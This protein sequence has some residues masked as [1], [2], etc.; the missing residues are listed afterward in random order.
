MLIRPLLGVMS[1]GGTR[2]RLSILIFHRV[3]PQVDPLFPQEMQAQRFDRLC[4]W[5]AQWFDVLPLDEAVRRLKG[6][7]LPQ[8]A[9]AITFDDGYADNHDVAMPILKKHGLCATFFIATGFLDGGRMWNDTVI[10]SV[11]LTPRETLPLQQLGV[12][13]LAETAVRSVAD[14]QAAIS[15][16]IRA[17]KYLPVPRRLA[18]TQE[19]ATLAQ[20]T[21]PT[22]LMMTRAQVRAMRRAGMQIGA[23]TVSHPILAQLAD[24]QAREEIQR[25]KHQLEDCLDEPI[26][27][28]AYPNG[29][30]GEDYAPQ[31]VQI[32]KDLGFE[33]AVSTAWGAS[34][35]QTDPFQIPRFTPW[36]QTPWRFALRL[37]TNLTRTENRLPSNDCCN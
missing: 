25:S 9:L 32:V 20:V 22:D 19:L 2:G 3:L 36:D 30:P 1:P 15:Q 13:G 31:S 33:A 35:A 4:G 6:G 12:S 34:N 7:S 21:P 23:H 16:I 27:L 24:E 5:L 17:I 10:E 28:F 14:K 8:R 26:T 18:L 11:R 37:M 29:K